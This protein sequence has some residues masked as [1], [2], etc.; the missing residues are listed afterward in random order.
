MAAYDF[1]TNSDI[2]FRWDNM[3]DQLFLLGSQDPQIAGGA[4][5]E[6]PLQL[7]FSS[8]VLAKKGGTPYQGS[9]SLGIYG[10][11]AP[12]HANYHLFFWRQ[13][14]RDVVFNVKL[15]VDKMT[16]EPGEEA[17]EA[18]WIDYAVAWR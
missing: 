14:Q 6:T 9:S 2:A 12:Q 4:A 15:A 1:W 5:R 17:F 18:D 8:A 10:H 11:S 3:G 7:A 13:L 16:I